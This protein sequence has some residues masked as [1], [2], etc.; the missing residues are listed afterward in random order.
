MLQN[1][2]QTGAFCY[3]IGLGLYM[4]YLPHPIVQG[5]WRQHTERFQKL[6]QARQ[7][8]L[9]QRNLS[10]PLLVGLLLIE[11]RNCLLN[12]CAHRHYFSFVLRHCFIR[13]FLCDVACVS[14]LQNGCNDAAAGTVLARVST[15]DTQFATTPPRHATE[16]REHAAIPP[17]VGI[18]EQERFHAIVSSISQQHLQHVKET[19]PLAAPGRTFL[20]R[21]PQ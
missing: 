11:F 9:I 6:T 7:N 4:S 5:I 20:H 3:Q 8:Q 16:K 21:P 18:T 17:V 14:E 1:S 10:R 2:A 15:H 13:L 19:H 12:V